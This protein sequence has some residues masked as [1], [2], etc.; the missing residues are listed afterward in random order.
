MSRKGES[1]APRWLKLDNAAKIYPPSRSRDWA[2]MF[3]VSVTLA[4]DIDAALLQ[5]AQAAALRR[6]PTFAY[7]LRRG[8]FWYYFDKLE[9]APPIQQD[10]AN[11]LVRMDLK[12]GGHFMFRVR[13]HHGRI[14]LEIFHALTDGTGALTFL[15]TM[16]AEYL[17][18]KYGQRIPAGGLIL[19]VNER[20][21]PQE[22]E[23]SFL[24][25]AR[26]VGASR[27]ETPAYHMRG[28]PGDPLKLSIT[29]GI[30]PTAKLL[31]VAR[32][33]GASATV[34]L[35]SVLIYAISQIQRGEPSARRRRQMVKVQVPV[36]LRP[37]YGATTL[38]N[39]ASYVNV[40]VN[41]ALGEFTLE[42]IITQ[43]KHQMGL[44]VTEKGLNARFSANVNS[45][46]FPL[47]RGMPLAVKAPFLKMMFKLQGDR[48]CST[49]LSNLGL[50]K[51][52]Q[53]MARYVTR[54]DFILGAPS[55]TPVVCAMIGVGEHIY[56]N[57][58]RTIREPAIERGFFTAL[59]KL[60][61]PVKVESNRR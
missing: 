19:G 38:R 4:E 57:M 43:V 15:L 22:M 18:L 32:G 55:A 54:M 33:Y 56:F 48:Y 58:S 14:A 24:T 6:I 61:I 21:L 30:I 27:A 41:S 23:D 44:E 60:G 13:C 51:L 42:E 46:K 16:T 17:R 47:V 45:E 5:K 49:T 11:P 59:V 9:G 40:G 29:T 3:R 36:N 50:V 20:P 28:T 35:S 26:D 2:A 10:V 31:A 39:F 37:F 1:G 7:R 12:S 8:F 52:P 34:F 53:E 25:Y